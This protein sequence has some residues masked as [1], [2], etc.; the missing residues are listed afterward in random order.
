VAKRGTTCAE[1]QGHTAPEP[2]DLAQLCCG[3]SSRFEAQ[4]HPLQQ[5][6]YRIQGGI[7]VIRLNTG[8]ASATA[9]ARRDM[10]CSTCT[11]RDLPMRGLATEQHTAR[12]SLTW[13][14]RSTNSPNFLLPPHHGVHPVLP[15]A[16]RRLGPYFREHTIDCQRLARPFRCGVPNGWQAKNPPRS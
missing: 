10:P 13:A 5:V 9:A 4:G 7:S 8:T 12:P 14:Q 3:D 11:R 1:R 2:F 15:T 16:S 6:D